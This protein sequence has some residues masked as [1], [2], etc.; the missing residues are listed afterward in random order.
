MSLEM[1]RLAL[2]RLAVLDATDSDQAM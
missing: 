1:S 2:G